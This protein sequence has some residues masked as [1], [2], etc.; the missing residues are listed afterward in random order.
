MPGTAAKIRISE[1]QQV[2]LE[3]LSRS[4]TVARCVVQRATIIL[5]GFQGWLNAAIAE[6]VQLHR[7]QVGVWRQRWR[8]TSE[9]LKRYG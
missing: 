6:E 7:Q 9:S 8:D 5:R 3:E 4:R 1:K 2:I